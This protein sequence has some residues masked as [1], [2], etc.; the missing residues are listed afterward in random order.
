MSR[1]ILSRPVS[2][3]LGPLAET[4][5]LVLKTAQQQG[6]SHAEAAASRNAGLSTTA[7]LGEVETLEYHKDQGVGV[8]VYFGQHKGHASASD[9]DPDAVR[10]TVRAACA[11]ARV[12][13]ADPYAGLADPDSLAYDYPDLD[14]DHPWPISAEQGIE[15]AIEIEA[16]ARAVDARITNS[17]G[18]SVV[19]GRGLTVY[20]NSHGFIG[21]YAAT[22]HSLSCA[23]IGQQD[24][25]MQR[26][27]WYSTARRETDLEDPQAIGRTAA[28][29]TLRRL[30]AQRLKTCQAPVLFE[31]EVARSLIRHFVSAISG[32]AL[33]RQA[34]FLL[35]SLGRQVFPEF[36]RIH[37][38]PHL[39]GATG[40]APFDSEG[41][42]TC[43]RDVVQA[44]VLQ[45][46]VLSSYSARRLNLKT[47]G[48]AGGVHNLTVE[49]G[50]QDL[51]GLIRQMHTGL[52]VTE[53]IG[54]GVNLVTGDYSRGA[55]GFWV[56]RGEIQYPVEE[57]TIAGHLK[58]MFLSLVAVGHDVDTRSA[59][60]CGSILLETMT[61]AGA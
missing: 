18:A 54:Q 26:D 5:E 20:G 40:S 59:L 14:L 16:A 12:A 13:E 36:V 33:Y 45:G 22:R 10:E 49:P 57:I 1:T 55:S 30:G 28:R 27:Y 4:V 61:I 29:R 11:I 56:E 32:G 8:T 7:R 15:L 9:L 31:P 6:A 39:K 19:S 52:L 58:D 46:Y 37:E 50:E 35:D 3:A 41:V 53:L 42:A 23:V 38:Q 48:N 24:D 43:A 47:T 25:Q 51:T 60:R 21:G 34:S 17:E 44:G 2:E